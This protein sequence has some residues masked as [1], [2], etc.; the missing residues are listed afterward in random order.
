M[1]SK[2]DLTLLVLV[3]NLGSVLSQTL[4]AGSGSQT[5]P[6]WLT[7]IIAVVGFLFL[8]FLIF[9]IKRA[10]CEKPKRDI[11]DLESTKEN[12]YVTQNASEFLRRNSGELKTYTNLGLE[13]HEDRVTHM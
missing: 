9:I 12:E 6:Q 2:V 5:L 3:L 10:W 8:T 4:L 11:M 13:R 1:R 7:G